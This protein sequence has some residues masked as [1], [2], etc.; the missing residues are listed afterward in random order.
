MYDSLLKGTAVHLQKCSRVTSTPNSAL[1]FTSQNTTW[2]TNM[3]AETV[4]FTILLITHTCVQ[5]LPHYLRTQHTH[6][7]SFVTY[8]LGVLDTSLAQAWY[9]ILLL[10]GF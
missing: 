10:P 1:N 6:I 4:T 2:P 3:A 5:L 9:S 7:H 8:T